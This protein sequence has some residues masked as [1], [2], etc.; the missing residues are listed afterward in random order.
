MIAEVY[1]T[2]EDV[3]VLTNY[4]T[5]KL[6]LYLTD[7]CY[8]SKHIKCILHVECDNSSCSAIIQLEKWLV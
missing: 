7:S 4:N 6:H 5:S 8:V 2:D 3:D 1:T